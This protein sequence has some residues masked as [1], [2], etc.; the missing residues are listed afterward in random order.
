MSKKWILYI[1]GFEMPDK[2]A[3]AQRVT[4][5]AKAFRDLGYETF[6]IGL[7]KDPKLINQIELFEG[8]KYINLSYPKNIWDWYKYLISIKHLKKHLKNQPNLIVAYNYPAIA[9]R[10]LRKWTIKNKI[11]LVSDCTEWYEAKG[12]IIFR[13]IKGLDTKYRMERVNLTLDGLIA[14]SDYLYK[15]Y[16][17]KM[18]NVINIP[19][20]VD[21]TMVKWNNNYNADKDN[22]ANVKLV[23]A[24][25]PG[26]GNKDRL[27]VV[28]NSLY[29]LKE[30]GLS[31]FTLCI[32]GMTEQQYINAFKSIIPIPVKENITFNGRLPHQETLNEIKE[33]HYNIFFR[34]N[35]L[36]NNAGFPTKFVEA[37][38]CGT[39]VI[40][41]STSNIDDY[42][43]HGENGYLIDF[44]NEAKLL[45]GVKNAIIVPKDKLRTMKLFCK[46]STP[47]D[48]RHFLNI[49]NK[50]LSNLDNIETH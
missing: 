3:A 1:G 27:D 36:T 30:K 28:I 9:L 10:K 37:I 32:I 2:N 33:A 29:K 11:P 43:K 19:P 47:F 42:L 40:T 20:L 18:N 45:E 7:S 21:L 4:A 8:F 22:S 5:N 41:N 24:G 34:D 12:N 25:S 48:Y 6:F 50:F 16:V 44:N 26:S 49:F 35:N 38:S 46:S 17:S 31:N 13:L 14:I 15:Y 39:P 23:Y